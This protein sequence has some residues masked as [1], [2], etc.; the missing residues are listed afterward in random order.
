M[1]VINTI[2]M[3][4]VMWSNPG[5]FRFNSI[6]QFR[7]QTGVGHNLRR[8]GIFRYYYFFYDDKMTLRTNQRLNVTLQ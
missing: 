4:E 3:N 6:I 1:F 5:K 7:A 8:F 2:E